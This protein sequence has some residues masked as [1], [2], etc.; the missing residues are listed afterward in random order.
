MQ[1]DPRAWLWDVRLAVDSI[2][3][4]VQGRSFAD[5][6]G[7]LMLRSAVERQFA[8]AGE[9]LNRLS[10]EA[11]E[12]AAQLPDLRRAIAMRNALIH[13]YREVDNATV[14]QTIHEDLPALQVQVEALLAKLGDNP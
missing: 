5:Y 12:I 13:G 4:F 11:P 14:W 7:D 2:A 6:A 9:A 1:H 3:T 8:I 10:R